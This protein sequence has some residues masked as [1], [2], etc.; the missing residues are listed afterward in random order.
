MMTLAHSPLFSKT[1]SKFL[2][3]VYSPLRVR[4]VLPLFSIPQVH[5]Q[6]SLSLPWSLAAWEVQNSQTCIASPSLKWF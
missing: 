2:V 5:L 6:G 1:Y 3:A 4:G